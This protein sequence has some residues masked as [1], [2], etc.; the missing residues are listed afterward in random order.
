VLFFPAGSVAFDVH[1]KN[2]NPL[3]EPLTIQR[4]PEGEFRYNAAEARGIKYTVYI[5]RDDEQLTMPLSDADRHRYTELPPGVSQRIIALAQ[6]WTREEPTAVGKAHIIEERLRKEYAYDTNSPSGGT[7][8][9]VAHFLFESKKGHC[10]FFST[11]MALMLRAVR[12]PSRNVTGFVGGTYNRFGKYYAVREG[13]A[14]SWVEAYIDN[15]PQSGWRT[16]DPTPTAGA[17]PLHATTGTWVY[18]RDF[19]EAVSQRWNANVV[20]YDLRQQMHLLDSVSNRYDQARRRAGLTSGLGELVTRPSVAGAVVGAAA[21]AAYALWRRRKQRAAAPDKDAAP[22]SADPHQIAS[23]YAALESAIAQHGLVRRPEQPPLKFAEHLEEVGHPLAQEV[24]S[25]TN[26]YLDARFG[27][28]T[29]TPETR[30][31]FD[32]RVRALRDMRPSAQA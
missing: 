26:V 28:V 2:E 32:G 10:E 8:E 13:D 1:N 23:L 14:H 24:L 21:V 31:E 4:G 15:G 29:M 5:G 17:Q 16:F 19:I 22:K 25:L 27:G 20:G 12:I 30:R 6:D 7:K 9:P 11:S 18:L 3:V